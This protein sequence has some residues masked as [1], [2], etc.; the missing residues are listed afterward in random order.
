MANNGSNDNKIK[1][2]EQFSINFGDIS[3]IDMNEITEEYKGNHKKND[4]LKINVD[5][6]DFEG[7][8]SRTKN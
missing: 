7:L 3:V 5:K 4:I 1:G 8:F 2:N 6:K